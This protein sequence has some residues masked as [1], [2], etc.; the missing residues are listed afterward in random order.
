MKSKIASFSLSYLFLL[1][2]IF[3]P[4][5]IQAQFVKKGVLFRNLISHSKGDTIEIY[6]KRLNPSTFSNQYL[7]DDNSLRFID[8]KKIDLISPEYDFWDELWFNERATEIKKNGW[9][10]EKILREDAKEFNNQLIQNYL[11]YYDDFFYDYLYHLVNKIHPTKLIKSKPAGFGILIM[12]SNESKSIVFDNGLIVLTTGLIAQTKSEE[13]LVKILAKCV[14]HV[15]LEHNLINLK[16]QITL[17]NRAE[18]WGT[19]AGVVSSAAMAYNSVNNDN[20]YSAGEIFLTGAS[21]YLLTK[22]ILENIGADYSSIQEIESSKIANE[23]LKSNRE[24]FSMSDEEYLLK[25][26]NII[27]YTAWQY[28][29]SLEYYKSLD[30]INRINNYGKLTQEDYLLLIKLKRVCASNEDDYPVI[31]SLIDECRKKFKPGLIELYK[32][33]AM[34]YLRQKMKNRAKEALINYKNG[35]VYLQ[36]D[37]INVGPEINSVM[38]L[39]DKL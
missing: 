19:A 22:S 13:E 36:N 24:K 3:F 5:E 6:G 18:F 27:S 31:I 4:I 33:E 1:F 38:Q 9:E 16:Q 34:I 28:Y 8:E 15:V 20:N 29:N 12:K 25:I 7:I 17:Q 39:L 30:L 32:E 35:L 10:Y 37:G 26:S 11:I 14:A 2:V 21:A 23:Y